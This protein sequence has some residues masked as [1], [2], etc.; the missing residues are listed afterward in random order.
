MEDK[1]TSHDVPLFGVLPWRRS[2]QRGEQVKK[3]PAEDQGL[4]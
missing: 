2:F 1:Q 3:Q 4:C